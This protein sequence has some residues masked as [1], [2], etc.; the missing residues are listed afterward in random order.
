MLC[1]FMC[2]IKFSY[3]LINHAE[4]F[5]TRALKKHKNQRKT[6]SY[7]NIM[8]YIFLVLCTNT[9]KIGTYRKVSAMTYA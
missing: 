1:A 7:I 8:L 6:Y 3:K 2:E 5:H 9:R 4:S